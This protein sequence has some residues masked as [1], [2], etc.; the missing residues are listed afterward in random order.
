MQEIEV[1][2]LEINRDELEKKLL[3]LG[4]AKHF[5]GEMY[6]IFY[7][8]KDGQIRRAGRVLRLRKEGDQAVLTFKSPVSLKEAKI[9]DEFE[10]KIGNMDAM[11]HILSQIG[12]HPIKETRKF[13]T[14]YILDG[15]KVVIDHYQDALAYIPVF[16][17]VEAPDLKSMKALVKKLGYSPEDCHSWST[18]DLVKHYQAFSK[19]K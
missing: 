15:C 17:E 3:S 8:F 18:Y 14:E 9:M 19:T 2:I 6:A 5:E 4:A 11:K 13:R 7:D 10:S 1:K 16:I 12:L